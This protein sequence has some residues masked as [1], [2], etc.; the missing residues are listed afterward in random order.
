M[1]WQ[2]IILSV[3]SSI[4]FLIFLIALIFGLIKKNRNLI[5]ISIFAFITALT[6]VLYVAY[7]AVS[8][9]YNTVGEIVKLNID[10]TLTDPID[11]YKNWSG[12]MPQHNVKVIHGTYWE[13]A[14]FTKEYIAFLEIEAPKYWCHELFKV[15]KMIE[16]TAR[17]SPIIDAPNWFIPNDSC[18]VWKLPNS[19]QNSRYFEDTINGKLF[20]YEIQL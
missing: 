20:I 11:C 10:S 8:K 3:L 4:L 18:R 15:N 17:I 5:I 16:D 19:F 9:T 12:E 13:S 7:F 14:H 1:F 2:I 6:L